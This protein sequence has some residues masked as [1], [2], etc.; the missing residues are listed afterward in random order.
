MFESVRESWILYPHLKA[1]IL[2][3]ALFLLAFCIAITYPRFGHRFLKAGEEAFSRLAQR[4]T[5]SLW[6]IA[7]VPMMLRIVLLP[8]LPVPQPNQEDEFAN[9]Y[10][11]ATF[12]QGRL[13][14]PSPPLAR[15]FES[16][17]VLSSP[18]SAS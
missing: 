15:H 3:A 16:P 8:W 5:L 9:M 2:E 7:F 6:L 13:A 4:K 17:M 1:T 10:A 12:A 14:N 18:N 11:A